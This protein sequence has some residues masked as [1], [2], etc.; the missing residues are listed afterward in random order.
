MTEGALRSWVETELT[1]TV[2]SDAN[3]CL[4]RARWRERDGTWGWQLRLET[5]E[6]V[7]AAGFHLQVAR[8]GVAVGDQVVEVKVR[9][10]GGAHLRYDKK[11]ELYLGGV[12]KAGVG[13]LVN[14]STM[15]LTELGRP[16]WR[17][18]CGGARHIGS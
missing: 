8:R 7:I 4:A 16:L 13:E 10:P 15:L 18:T 17:C 2:C 14:I 5:V 3:V 6:A 9:R 1:G 12:G 11:F